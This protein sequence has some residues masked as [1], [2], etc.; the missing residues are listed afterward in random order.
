MQGGTQTADRTY[1]QAMEL[2]RADYLTRVAQL[3]GPQILGNLVAG[4]TGRRGRL[5]DSVSATACAQGAG[6]RARWQ[7]AR[8]SRPI[9][10]RGAR[11][12][13]G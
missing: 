12:V 1:L 10:R 6:V 7:A 11:W 5:R 13:L 9:P 4:F 3:H 8:R 2:G